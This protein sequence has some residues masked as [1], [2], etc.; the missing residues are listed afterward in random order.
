MS[1]DQHRLVP[2]DAFNGAVLKLVQCELVL[3]GLDL[4]PLEVWCP[5][6]VLWCNILMET[7]LKLELVYVVILDIVAKFPQILGCVSFALE[8]ITR[9]A[10]LLEHRKAFSSQLCIFLLSAIIAQHVDINR[11]FWL[12]CI[13]LIFL[14]LFDLVQIIC[15]LL[16]FVFGRVLSHS[17]F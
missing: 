17:L 16:P 15:S 13:S 7:I 9:L 5:F 3:L 14:R 2:L 12:V 11:H 6:V 8:C 4:G 1:C 10:Y